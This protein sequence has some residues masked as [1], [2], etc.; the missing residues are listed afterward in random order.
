VLVLFL[1]PGAEAVVPFVLSMLLFYA[2]DPSVDARQHWRVPRAIGAALMLG[3]VL[4][5]V[6]AVTFTLRDD[7]AKVIAEL[8]DGLRRVLKLLHYLPKVGRT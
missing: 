6:A 8:P 5:G 2:V 3:A 7:V 1:R 4:T